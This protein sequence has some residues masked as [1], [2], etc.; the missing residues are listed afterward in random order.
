[1]QINGN[2]DSSQK[3]DV[4]I[5]NLVSDAIYIKLLAKERETPIRTSTDAAVSVS[6][7]VI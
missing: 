3:R 4:A 6:N 2:G 5:F 7:A 1:M